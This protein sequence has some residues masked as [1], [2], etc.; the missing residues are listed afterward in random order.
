[1]IGSL[2]PAAAAYADAVRSL[3]L[4]VSQTRSGWDDTARLAFDRQ[5]TDPLLADARRA[6]TELSQLA[7]ELNA[8][9]RLLTDSA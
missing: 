6:A 1:M 4:A 9:A 7:Q 5:Y 8:A 2:D 3:D